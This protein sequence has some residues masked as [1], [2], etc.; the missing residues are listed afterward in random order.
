MLFIKIT[1]QTKA[2]RWIRL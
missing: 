1:E 2:D